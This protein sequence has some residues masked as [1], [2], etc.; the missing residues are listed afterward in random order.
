M[1]APTGLPLDQPILP[2]LLW[3][4]KVESNDP[5]L[6]PVELGSG[7]TGPAGL[8]VKPLGLHVV[9]VFSIPTGPTHS[10]A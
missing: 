10:E 1:D 2:G 4:A 5:I 9:N 8:A 7:D 6:G 3:Q